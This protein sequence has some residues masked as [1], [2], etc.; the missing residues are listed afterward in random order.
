MENKFPVRK[1]PRLKEY[2]Y[3]SEG[4]YFVTFCVKNMRQILSTVDV[5]R[6]AL[7]PPSVRLSKAGK[8]TQKYIENINS[9]YENV[10]VDKYVIMPNHVHMIIIIEPLP[11]SGGM[12]ASRPTLFTVVRSV[13]TMIT[14]EL[15]HSIW[16]D[17]YYERVIRGDESYRAAWQYIDDNP[18]KWAE[19]KYY[20]QGILE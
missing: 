13:K 3:G 14:R 9:A 1:H 10:K 6:D 11:E 4:Y 8:V 2:D 16:Q 17:S 19:D 12:R 15:G 20:S 18:A 7:I 5:G